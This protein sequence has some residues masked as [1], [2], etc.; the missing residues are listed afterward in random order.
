[1][2]HSTSQVLI[3]G[4][5]FVRRLKSDLRVQFDERAFRH[6][7]LCGSAVVH[8]H[9]VGGRT[10]GKLRKYDLGVVSGLCP[11]VLILEIWPFL[12]QRS[13]VPKSK[14]LFVFFWTNISFASLFYATLLRARTLTVKLLSLTLTEIAALRNQYTRVVLE[15]VFC[16]THRGFS[17]PTVFPFLLDGAHFNHMCQ[18]AFYRRYRICCC[19]W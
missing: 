8:M 16:W 7:G 2:A 1:M 4:N 5:S 3:I 12:N 15:H 6:F 17:N 19:M 11:D 13:C 10:V 18:F 14:S 9:G